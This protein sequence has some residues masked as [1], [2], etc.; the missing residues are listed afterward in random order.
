MNINWGIIVILLLNAYYWVNVYYN[1][2]FVTTI[3]TIVLAAIV[4]IWLRVSGRA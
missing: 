2:F 3:W 4:G 1:G